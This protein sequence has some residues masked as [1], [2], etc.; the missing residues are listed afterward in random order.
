MAQAQA[1]NCLTEAETAAL[2]GYALPDL[3]AGVRDKCKGSLAAPTFLMSRSAELERSYRRHSDAL[4]PTAKAAFAKMVGEDE[5]M[6]KMPDSALR[7]L[8]TAAFGTV[9]TND[10]KASDCPLAD[11]IVEALAPLPPAN[12]ARLIGLIIAA[13]D[14]GSDAAGKTGFAICE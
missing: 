12:L 8:L 1:R 6:K 5:M 10:V 13:D 7:P 11:G 14:K 3:L 9:I 4:W 2:I